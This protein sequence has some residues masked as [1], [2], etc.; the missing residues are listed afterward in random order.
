ML[1]A[2]SLET[3][4]DSVGS[5]FTWALSFILD[6]TLLAILVVLPLAALL[7]SYFVGVFRG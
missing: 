5:L 4:L 6:N 7:I 3:T 2:F 1:A